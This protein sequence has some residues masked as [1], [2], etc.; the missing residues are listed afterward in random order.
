[1]LV[2]GSLATQGQ[3]HCVPYRFSLT[4]ATSAPLVFCFCFCFPGSAQ[5]HWIV[6]FSV[7][8]PR[9]SA[10]CSM[11]RGVIPTI[12]TQ[13]RA[14]HPP[15]CSACVES[16]FSLQTNLFPLFL[17]NSSVSCGLS[18]VWL[19]SGVCDGFDM[20]SSYKGNSVTSL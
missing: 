2:A 19:N 10:S 3:C 8:V 14:P 9:S 4:V 20:M 15:T 1:M 18:T 17:P 13:H 12:V 5:G 16:P 6:C 7:I 11:Y